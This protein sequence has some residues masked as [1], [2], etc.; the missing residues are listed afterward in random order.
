MITVAHW[1]KLPK[2]VLLI[3]GPWFVVGGIQLA[4]LY[5]KTVA[6]SVLSLEEV[7]RYL[8]TFKSFEKKPPDLIKGGGIDVTNTKAQAGTQ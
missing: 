6:E 5:L 3:A 4:L 1:R 8:E 2:R 7:A